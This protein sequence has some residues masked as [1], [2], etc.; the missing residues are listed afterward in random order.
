MSEALDYLNMF[1]RYPVALGR[2]L[3]RGKFNLADAQRVAREGVARRGENFLASI[4]R[5]IFGWPKSPYLPL[6]QQAGCELGDIE[7]LVRRVG[8][9]DA[10][11]ELRAAGVYVTFEEFKG[12]KPIE[13]PGLRLPVKASDFDNPFARRDFSL[14]SSGSTGLATYVGMDLDY[15]AATAH[16]QLLGLAAN[17][18]GDV[19]GVLLAFMLPAPTPRVMLQHALYD[20]IPRRWFVP[21]GPRDM[22]HWLK[23]NVATYYMLAWM[24]AYGLAV[25]MPEFAR[26]DQYLAVARYL[27]ALLQEHPT[28]VLFTGVSRAVRVCLAAEEAGLDLTGVVIRAGGEP[29]TPSKVAAMGRVGA[30]YMPVYA[31][32][33]TGSLGVGCANPIAV[34]DMHLVEDKIAL[35]THPYAVAGTTVPA[36]NYT[37]LQDSAPKMMLNVQIDDYGVVEKRACGCSLED[38]GYTTHIHSIRSYSKLT[39]EGVTLVGNEMARILEEDLPARYGGSP[40]DYQLLEEEDEQ[41][42]TRLYLLVSPRLQLDDE[43]AVLD[44]V[45]QALGR[46]SSAADV[47]RSVWQR[48][49][50][51]RLRRAEPQSTA[52]G[53]VLPLH[54]RRRDRP[55]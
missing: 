44:T 27:H 2:C 5:G 30:R 50:A 43:Q 13:R 54:I 45:L 38:A 6:L 20:N 15:V 22:R 55:A 3:R 51:L 34:G 4:K 7:V 47:A 28:C 48:T 9:D 24:R 41:G 37:S 42:F 16:I 33:E 32:M 12:R 49:G 18:V 29:P 46:S 23:Y 26:A 31:S 17:G 8:L 11:R 39:G 1:V 53:K 21:G 36:F 10:L 14:Q 19:P 52:N 40:M 35:I 25:P